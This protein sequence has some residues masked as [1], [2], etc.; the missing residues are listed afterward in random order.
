[1]KITTVLDQVDLGAMALPE[2]QRGYVWTRPQVRSLMHSLYRRHPVGSLLIWKTQSEAAAARGDA[3][4]QLGFVSLLLDGQQRMTSLYG[5]IRG[6]PPP[7]FEGNENAFTDLRFN[8]DDERFEFFAPVT[9]RDDP[10]WI[11]VTAVM[12]DGPAA[13]VDELTERFHGEPGLGG[14]LARLQRLHDI[15]EIEL[16]VEEVTG[17][18]KTVDVVV[19]IFNRVNSGG[20]KLSKGD[21]ALAKICAEWPEA[22]GAMHSRWW[23][24]AGFRFSLDWL[25][26]NINA[27]VTGRAE[28]SALAGETTEAF[29]GGLQRAERAIDTTLNLVTA[30]LGLDH[31]R[32]LGGRG[33]VPLMSRLV[34]DRDFRLRDAAEAD[35]LLYWYVQSF[36]WGRYAGDPL[37]T[38]ATR[39]WKRFGPSRM[40]Q[41]LL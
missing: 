33:A 36:L 18:D 35:G 11:D 20:T 19:D 17:E 38:A 41:S 4:V 24:D 13:L 25:L 21:L 34:S 39:T 12:R 29:Q 30:R 1:M 26:R 23:H 15:R 40:T 8:L 10:L 5:L 9:M 14:Y 27:I 3:P 16:H 7:F 37:E 31:D 6:G 32:V 2:F 28:F 22:R